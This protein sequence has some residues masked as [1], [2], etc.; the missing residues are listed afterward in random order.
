MMLILAGGFA[1]SQAFRTVASIF[2]VPLAQELGMT[3]RQ[4]GSWSATFHLTFGL[5]QF[6][7]GVALDVYGPRR[8]VLTAAPLAVVGAAVC[9]CAPAY[10]ALLIGQVLIGLGCAPAFL[11]CTVFVAREFDSSRFTSLSGLC[12]SFSSL[13]ILYTGTPLAYI[14]E[15]GSWR[16]GYWSLAALA[17]LSTGLIA[18]FVRLRPIAPLPAQPP[19]PQQGFLRALRE[20]LPLLRI[21]HTA[22]L[23][24]FALVSYASMM[25]L[26]GLW[27]GPLLQERHGVSLIVVGN[28]A[29]VMTV[30][31]MIGPT[32]FGRLD[33]GGRRRTRTMVGLALTLAAILAVMAFTRSQAIDI[34]GA[35][36]AGLLS[37][38]GIWQY[39]YMKN[40]YAPQQTGRIIALANSSMFLGVALMQWAT[41]VASTW[42]A[43]HGIETFK[44]ALLAMAVMLAAGT[45]AFAWLPQAQASPES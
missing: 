43:R 32:L 18:V 1:V 24:C 19:A 6:M 42:A 33:P 41:G 7:M 5:S 16:L 23:L 28:V 22:G 36:V 40:A 44:A 2:S 26:R 4:L 14:V 10:E 45:L 11:A 13:G 21:R 37:G 9:A 3:T 30:G 12:M 31:A 20:L 39:A 38:Y 25:T 17:A 8:T 29:V 27:L 15:H 35:I 34:V